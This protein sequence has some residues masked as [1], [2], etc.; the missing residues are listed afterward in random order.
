MRFLKAQYW[1]DWLFPNR[2]PV[3]NKFI[4]WDMLLC[5]DCEEHLP[6]LENNIIDK[7]NL[8]SDFACAVFSYEGN[9]VKGIYRL[10]NSK[11]MNLAEYASLHLYRTLE[12]SKMIND[13]DV[14]TCV[15][16]AR[17]KKTK[18]GYNHA[19]ILAGYMS[20]LLDKPVDT[21]LLKHKNSEKE[22]HKLNSDD[23]LRNADEVYY[24]SP[25]H[26]NIQGKN[27][28][29]CDDVITT[30]A[31]MGKCVELLRAMGAVKVAAAAICATRIEVYVD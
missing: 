6:F 11:G 12:E 4:N 27:V 22:Q 28:L 13:I 26:Q 23:R 7:Q 17:K 10:K 20:K 29:V 9:V 18:R 21:T 1:L 5:K 24:I 8:K 15:P 14:V 19:E 25:K 3:C 31:T 16:M 2:C 30:G